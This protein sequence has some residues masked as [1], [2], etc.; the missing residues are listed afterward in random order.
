MIVY[1]FKVVSLVKKDVNSIADSVISVVWERYGIDE[2]GYTGKYKICTNLDISQVGISTNHIPYNNL[3]KSDILSWI[4]SIV[5]MDKVVE[6]INTEI[7][8]SKENQIQVESGNLPWEIG[9]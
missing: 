6:Y 3:T 8:K 1:T 4:K 9:G 5:N 2:Q 7:E